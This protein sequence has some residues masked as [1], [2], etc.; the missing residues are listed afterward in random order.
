MIRV[1]L[2]ED[3]F[4]VREGTRQLL[5]ST[6]EV[7]VVAAVDNPDDLLVA[8]AEHQPNVA[9]VDIRMPPTHQTEGIDAALRIRAEHSDVGVVILSQHANAM[10]ALELFREGTEGL[11][12]LLK[13]RVGD[14]AEL[15]RAVKEV[16][17]RG[18]VVDPKVV[19]GL[20][21]RKRRLSESMLDTLT[22]REL[23]ELAAMAQGMSNQ[24]VADSLFV[25]QSAIEKHINSIFIKLGLS[26]DETDTHRRVAAVL[27]YLQDRES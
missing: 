26:P 21:N 8:V 27:A 3:H 9:I 12:Y 24:A 4:L 15:L 17:A 11:A 16:M 20:V 22:T 14:V 1:V 25:S 18:S 23:D 5:E 19:D 6:R 13:D 10:Y 7:E 2:A